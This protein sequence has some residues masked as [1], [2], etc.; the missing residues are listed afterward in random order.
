MEKIKENKVKYLHILILIVGIIFISLSIFHTNMWFDE[1]YSIGIARHSF[2]EIWNISSNDVHPIFY[3][4]CLHV[5]YLIFG[6]NIIIYRVFSAIT[7]ALLGLIGYTHIRKDFGERTGLLFSFLALFLPVSNQYA[8]EIRM[9]SLGM[10]LGTIMAIYAYRIYKNDIKKCTYLIFGASSLALAYTHYYGVLLAA[11][12]NVIL[13]VY[14]LKNNKNRKKDLIKFIITAIIQVLLYIPWLVAFL[15]NLKGTG[16]WISLSFPGTIYEILTMQYRGNL[17]FSPIILTTLFYVYIAYLVIKTPKE[18]RKPATWS[19]MIYVGI[20]L[21]VLLICLIIHSVILL[22]RY[23]LIITGI[24]IFGLA[25]F[26]ARDMK[27][28]RLITICAIIL[29]ISSYSNIISIKEN[30]NS[31]NREFISYLNSE[32]KEN[33]IILYRNAINGAVITTEV[34]QEHE[35]TSY[36]YD[37]DHW[38][39]EKAYKAFGPYME[40]RQDLD[41]ILENY[42]GRIWIVESANTHELLDEVS[43]KYN[44]NKLEEKQ[45]TNKY[46][47]YQYTIELIEKL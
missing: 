36:F 14:L 9:Y 22:S 46:K 11:L 28:S 1:S 16:F 37:K 21:L 45:F 39:V 43:E 38:N 32:I 10:L 12:V 29:I 4:F 17:A 34:S 25:Y 33:D 18:E 44:V 31:N 40:I 23:L 47:N 19:F 27:K 20:I 5:L 30:Y 13:F 42:T 24:F 7:I 41:E 6:E 3:Y 8:G 35:N 15:S 2:S 26:M